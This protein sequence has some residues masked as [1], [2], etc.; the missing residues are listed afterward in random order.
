MYHS[1]KKLHGYFPSWMQLSSA[2][3]ELRQDEAA[4][5]PDFQQ[6]CGATAEK[7]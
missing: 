5:L 2:A 3:N 1:S 7:A 6:Q 4:A